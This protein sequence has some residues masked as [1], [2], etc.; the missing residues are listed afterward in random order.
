MSIIKSTFDI[1]KTALFPNKC[2]ICGSVIEYDRQLCDA[3]ENA[4]RIKPPI[5]L[6]CGCEKAD[7]I[8]KKDSH[9]PEYKAVIAPYYY[10]DSIAHGI[11]NCKMNDLPV[12]TKAQGAEIAKSVK[13][14][15]E[16]VDF[17][18]VSYIPMRRYDE[19]Y[20]GFNQSALL[21]EEVAGICGYEYKALLV[22]KH[23]TKMQKRQ[24]AEN[25]YVNMY[26]A[27]DLAENADVAD[28]TI[29]LIDDVKTTGATLSSAAL[30]LK[31]Y[32]AKAVYCAVFAIV[33]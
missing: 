32:G 22:K 26:N 2:C 7:C 28:K 13:T 23:R 11:L 19:K 3:C 17:D 16:L 21:A 30:T 6:K 25:R 10:Q 29:L 31:A 14:F 24:R 15:Y 12:L 33:K 9:K 1:F 20:R 4:E 5:C 27:F 8:C 18:C